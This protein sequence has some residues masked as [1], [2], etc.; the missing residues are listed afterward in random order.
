[1]LD[2][3]QASSYRTSSFVQF[4]RD[5]F[6][7]NVCLLCG[8]MHRLYIHG[9]VG[10]LIRNAETEKNEEIVICVIICHIAKRSGSRYTKRMLPPFVT[11]DCTITLENALR[12]F[13]AMPQGQ[14]D[15]SGAGLLLGTVCSDTI[16]RHYRMV[17]A[18]ISITVSAFAEYL[19]LQAPFVPLPELRPDESP[20]VHVR[21]LMQAVYEAQV[22]RSGRYRTAPP[23]LPYLHLVCVSHKSRSGSRRIKPSNFISAIRFF[24]DSS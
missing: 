3:C 7:A 17:F 1:M 10:R 13:Q 18:L 21:S 19:S 24:F 8:R 12:M 15:Y 5:Y 11:P 2:Y 16:R 9:Y 23:V 22:S 14:I 6:A 4:L 20:L